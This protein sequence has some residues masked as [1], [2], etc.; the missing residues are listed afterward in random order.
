M[1]SYILSNQIAPT[2]T[3][4]TDDTGKVHFTGLQSGLYLVSGVQIVQDDLT[5]LFD[6]ALIALPGL[7]ADGFWQYSVS[8]AA[9]P[10]VLP[11]VGPDGDPDEE[12][13][14]DI[15]F[16]VVKLWKGDEGNKDRP[17]DIE[18]EIFRNG[19]SYEIKTLSEENHWAYS[20]KAKNDGASWNV[21]ERNIPEG[22]TMTLEKRGKTFILTNVFEPDVPAISIEDPPE[23]DDVED[24]EDI[25]DIDD[26]DDVDDPDISEDPKVP[27]GNVPQTGDTTNILLYAV[28][29]FVSGSILLILGMTEKR[30]RHEEK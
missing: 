29:M 24:I 22:Y 23:K 14:G 13:D 3:A 7:N 1:E 17:S 6:S 11:P 4:V 30:N 28:L 20:W 16:K 2:G 26:V 9:K 18:I 5:C 15:R 27:S 12:P 8:A 25:E 10:D 21:A 19:I